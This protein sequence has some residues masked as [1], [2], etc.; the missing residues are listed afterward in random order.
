MF[1]IN[2]SIVTLEFRAAL[3]FRLSFLI[4]DFSPV[5]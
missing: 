1:I 2:D 4:D 5:L 3:L